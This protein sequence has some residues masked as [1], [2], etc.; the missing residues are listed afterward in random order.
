MEGVGGA[1]RGG[2]EGGMMRFLVAQE[3]IEVLGVR[4]G[5]RGRGSRH[6]GSATCFFVGCMSLCIVPYEGSSGLFL[7]ELQ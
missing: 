5:G 1:G 4:E 3:N 7:K 6:K 2:V